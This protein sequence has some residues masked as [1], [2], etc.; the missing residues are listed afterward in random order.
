[1][2]GFSTNGAQVIIWLGFRAPGAR[3]QDVQFN[4]IVM[5]KSWFVK[6]ISCLEV[7]DFVKYLN[8]S[9]TPSFFPGLRLGVW[10]GEYCP[11]LLAACKPLTHSQIHSDIFKPPKFSKVT[12]THIFISFWVNFHRQARPLVLE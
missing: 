5:E 2:R 9:P 11:G 3:A 8:G 12:I 10:V 7:M 1:M 4:I 6:E